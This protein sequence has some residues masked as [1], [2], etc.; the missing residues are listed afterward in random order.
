MNI[1]GLFVC[2]LLVLP[3]YW[4][5]RNWTYVELRRPPNYNLYDFKAYPDRIVFGD[6]TILTSEEIITAFHGRE[7]NA[8]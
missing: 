7:N 6:G 4:I 1:P 2:F 3:L 5:V 8:G